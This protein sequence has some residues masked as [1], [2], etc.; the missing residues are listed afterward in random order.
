[1][2]TD[3]IT[4]ERLKSLL[5]YDPD[6]GEFRWRVNRTG[7][8]K[9]GDQAKAKDCHGY[10]RIKLDGRVYK[11]HRVAWMYVYGEWPPAHID[12]IN[13]VRDDNRIANLRAVSHAENNQNRSA[14]KRNTSGYTGVYFNK[15]SRKWQA[16]ISVNGKLRSLGYFDTKE[17]AAFARQ[18]AEAEHLPF[19]IPDADT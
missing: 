14:D 13:R 17:D 16:S 10:G 5:T 11:A 18:R 4:Q 7:G 19:R 8:V 2:A 12:H 6:T 3:L 9:A 15:P 1:M